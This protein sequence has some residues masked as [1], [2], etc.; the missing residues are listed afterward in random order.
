MCNISDLQSCFQ[1]EHIF[2]EIKTGYSTDGKREIKCTL[3]YLGMS[4]CVHKQ[5]TSHFPAQSQFICLPAI[6]VRKSRDL[7]FSS[8]GVITSGNL[9]T[10]TGFF[11]GLK[12]HSGTGT[13]DS[14]EHSKCSLVAWRG[15]HIPQHNAGDLWFI[16][17]EKHAIPMSFQ[18]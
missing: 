15:H 12:S 14:C 11:Q 6:G 8:I 18:D 7:P 9:K 3:S 4:L 17:L 1:E 5:S 10:F 13:R 16:C 2:M